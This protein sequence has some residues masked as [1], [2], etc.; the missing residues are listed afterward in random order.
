[1]VKATDTND[2]TRTVT[3][4]IN[5]GAF[6]SQNPVTD[7]TLDKTEIILEKGVTATVT[8][9]VTPSDASY[10]NVKA[11]SSNTG[12]ATV[13]VGTP[14]GASSTV[15]V[16][17]GYNPGKATVT[18]TSVDSSLQKTF[19]VYVKENTPN[20]GVNY[21][22][23][24]LTSLV[25]GATYSVSGDGITTESFTAT[26]ST[27]DINSE[28]I[29]K[30]IKLVRTNTET[31]CNS[32]AQIIAIPA[33][34]A[35]PT[36]VAAVNES[37]EG[38]GDGKITGVDSSM[39]YRISGADSWSS[40]YSGTINYLSKGTYEVRY[41]ATSSSFAS[42][43]VILTVGT[44]PLSFEDSIT[45]DIPEGETG[46]SI[47]Q[48]DVSGAVSGGTHPYTFSKESGP[49]WLQVSTGGCI[50]GTR[51]TAVADATTA[52]IK[53]T[54]NTGTSKTI[55]IAIGAVTV[56]TTKYSITVTDGMATNSGV[57]ISEAVAGTAITVVADPAPA[58]TKFE[59]WVACEGS[60]EVVFTDA[61]SSTTTFSMPSGDVIIKAQYVDI[62]VEVTVSGTITSKGNAADSVTLYLYL[63][64]G[65]DPVKTCTMAGNT[66]SYSF[67]GV[68][69][70][71][72]YYIVAVKT[73]NKV[74]TS[75]VF[76]SG[77]TDITGYNLTMQELP[78]PSITSITNSWYGL[79]VKWGKVSG[80]TGYELYSRV[81]GTATWNKIATT[82]ATSYY[83][84]STV[85]GKTYEYMV[86]TKSGISISLAGQVSNT[87]FLAPPSISSVENLSTGVKVTWSKN[88]SATGYYVYRKD[89]QAGTWHFIGATKS[90]S[91]T[92]TTVENG[93]VYYYAVK[94]YSGSVISSSSSAKN[95]IYIKNVFISSL[96]NPSTKA[97]LVKYSSNAKATGYEIAYSPYSTMGPAST[98]TVTVTGASNLSKTIASL[99]K[100]STYYVKVRAYKTVAGYKFYSSWSAVKSIKITK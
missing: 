87:L 22:N 26:G 95:T 46:A 44:E 72:N 9:T 47:S 99:N 66:A 4:T 35:A 82:T 34:P 97:M 73:G 28:W 33:R 75:A 53:V 43:A 88:S 71:K 74:L 18:I 65:A 78:A 36:G 3:F 37:Y 51:P 89:T 39:E 27:Y 76:N 24:E 59:K 8:A 31:K 42:E 96:T 55:E 67:T 54:D 100:G 92:D 25:S 32:D 15:Q 84:K 94:A 57:G 12:I 62:Y 41:Y 13:S 69:G 64:G 16:T 56:A 40:I 86:K 77:V 58:G 68:E 45:F 93:V 6:T 17:A 14:S 21:Y 23:E 38:A 83:D 60:A 19:D 20:A 90:L 52:V 98:K 50:T 61:T 2:S 10:P 30:S 5:Y 80:A 85:N 1:T 81:K 79:T 49:D 48:V 29:G 63:E 11:V 7:M 91:Y 70:R